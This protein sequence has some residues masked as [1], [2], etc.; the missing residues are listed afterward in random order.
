M[1]STVSC[2]TQKAAKYREDVELR[3]K[4]ILMRFDDLPDD[5]VIDIRVVAA[6]LNRSPSSIWRDVANGRMP[7]PIKIGGST[8]FAIGNVRAIARG[9]R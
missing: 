6:V 1:T 2:G 9:V 8:R 4:R 7:K 3:L 5:A